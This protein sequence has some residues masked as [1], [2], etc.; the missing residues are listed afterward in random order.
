MNND[1]IFDEERFNHQAFTNPDELNKTLHSID[2]IGKSIIKTRF[3]GIEFDSENDWGIAIASSFAKIDEPIVLTLDDNRNFELNFCEEGFVTYGFDNIPLEN[4]ESYQGSHFLQ[5]DLF[6]RKILYSPITNIRVT[7]TQNMPYQAGGTLIPEAKNYIDDVI[8]EFENGYQIVFGGWYDYGTIHIGKMGQSMER[9]NED[10][11]YRLDEEARKNLQSPIETKETCK[12]RYEIWE[13]Q[14]CGKP[15]HT[16]SHVNW[17][18]VKI[19]DNYLPDYQG[20]VDFHYQGH[21]SDEFFSIIKGVVKSITVR[22]CNYK[23]ND[24][25]RRILDKEKSVLVK[26]V[27]GLTESEDGD[28][29]AYDYIVELKN[30]TIQ[31]TGYKLY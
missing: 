12:V 31:D 3:V 23:L 14:C 2:L 16:G 26:S 20:Q 22:Y 30:V 24:K 15:F 17:Y 13:M 9:Q 29:E 27:D 4:I 1:N 11:W 19:S 5:S 25:G 10:S 18:G 7:K 21:C 8:F 28:W 6:F